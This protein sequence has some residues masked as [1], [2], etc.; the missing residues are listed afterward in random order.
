MRRLKDP[1]PDAPQTFDP[2]PHRWIMFDVDGAAGDMCSNA[3]AAVAALKATLPSP[4]NTAACYWQAS[5]S[6]GIKPGVRA[7]LWYWLD[8]AVDDGEAK[9]IATGLKAAYNVDTQLYHAIQPHFCADPVFVGGEDPMEERSGLIPGTP[10]AIV[11]LDTPSVKQWQIAEKQLAD[12][13]KFLEKTKEGQR[14]PKSYGAAK[15]LGR[16]SILDDRT[17]E[18]ALQD[19]IGKAGLPTEESIGHIRRGL[20]AGRAEKG[21]LATLT[22]RNGLRL[23][24]TGEIL[25]SIDNL[26]EIVRTHPALIGAFVQQTRTG[27][28][29]VI[30]EVPW[31]KPGDVDDNDALGL[32]VWL[33]KELGLRCSRQDT[34]ALIQAE[35]SRRAFDPFREYLAA[36]EWDGVERLSCMYRL[37][38]VEPSGYA[39]RTFRCWMIS[40][41][42]RT[43]V[44]GCQADHMLILQSPEQGLYKSAALR[45]LVPEPELFT[46]FGSKG[47]DLHDADSVMKLHGPVLVCVDEMAAFKGRDAE[48]IKSFITEVSDFYRPKYGKVPKHFPRTNVFC[49][50]SNLDIIFTDGTGARR[51]WPHFVRAAIDVEALKG[52]RD[53]LWAEAVAAFGKGERHYLLPAEVEALQ[54]KQHQEARRDVTPLEETLSELV[55]GKVFVKTVELAEGLGISMIELSRIGTQ[56]GNSMRA[57][58]YENHRPS[59]VKGVGQASGW[60]KVDK[61]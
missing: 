9:R 23:S 18:T 15:D 60:R 8:R 17:L 39:E 33:A 26:Q 58:G 36:L 40:A 45:A 61:K 27:T 22:W 12:I 56:F 20:A 28:L 35:A 59:P 6:A 52:L 43:F 16:T 13:C 44:P 7:H 37:F 48:A 50:T 11:P 31:R 29:Q 42:A 5:A 34:W 55:R 21:D 54:V 53:Q 46:T 30:R 49:G 1:R 3:Q 38:Q 41:V 32:Q 2:A 51:F 10:E 19:A 14:A 47:R 24:E 57:L 25:P 4:W